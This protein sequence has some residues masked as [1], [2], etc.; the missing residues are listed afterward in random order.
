M[1]SISSWT[2]RDGLTLAYRDY[3]G[4]DDVPP[5]LCMHG[6]TRN[7]RDFQGFADRFEGRFRIIAPDFRGRGLSDRDPQ[8]ERYVPP[9]YAADMIELLDR[10]DIAQAILVGTSLGGIV[11]MLIAVTDPKR[12]AGTILNDVGP[13]LEATGLHRIRQYAGKPVRFESWDEAADY[14]RFIGRGL[15]ESHG[16]DDWLRV[17]KRLFAERDGS[18]ELDYDMGIANAFNPPEGAEQPVFDMW[19]LYRAL[20]RAPLL[21][22]RGETS[23][24]L[25]AQAAAR[26]V[27]EVPGASLVT[28]P[29]VGHPPD[30]TEPAAVAAIDSFLRPFEQAPLTGT[31][32][33]RQTGAENRS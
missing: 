3:P 13:E 15:P 28:V 31:S 30:L 23:D 7:S 27:E 11:A 22:V 9:T 25:S 6:L 12:I 8:P 18:I 10:L 1:S 20:G 24:L 16:R 4:R 29:G 14:A 33:E 21:I 19:P 5:L 2:G 17:A 26:M 32:E